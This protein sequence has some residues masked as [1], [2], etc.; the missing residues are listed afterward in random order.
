MKKILILILILL[1]A[2]GVAYWLTY[3]VSLQKKQS[4]FQADEDK[5]LAWLKKEF[6]LTPG[7]FARVKTLHEEYLPICQELCGK[8][9]ASNQKVRELMERSSGMNGELSQAL[10]ENAAVRAESRRQMLRHVYAVAAEMDAEQSRRY[11]AMMSDHILSPGTS[12]GAIPHADPHHGVHQ[13]G[14]HD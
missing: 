5:T 2:G 11:L 10:D 1:C 13:D 3:S 7:Q 14:G 8:V 9:N 4:F 12:I 6:G